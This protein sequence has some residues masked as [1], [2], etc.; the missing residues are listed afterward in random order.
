MYFQRI[1]LTYND[2]QVR[3]IQCNYNDV[4]V[5]VGVDGISNIDTSLDD[6][7]RLNLDQHVIKK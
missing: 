5:S 3:M 4:G 2:F 7:S 6:G 1:A